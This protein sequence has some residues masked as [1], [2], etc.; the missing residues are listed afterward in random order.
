MCVS[1]DSPLGTV[2][3]D[4]KLGGA[5]SNR[6]PFFD[7]TFLYIPF[8]HY[9]EMGDFVDSLRFFYIIRPPAGIYIYILI[10]EFPRI[11]PRERKLADKILSS[12]GVGE[13]GKE[14]HRR[15]GKNRRY[16]ARDMI[17]KTPSGRKKLLVRGRNEIPSR[18]LRSAILALPLRFIYI[19]F[20]TAATL[21][22]NYSYVTRAEFRYIFRAR[23]KYIAALTR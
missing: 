6:T 5:A 7:L 2:E 20:S 12:A 9:W 17:E 23:Y 19:L 10:E 3:D 1:W 21:D 16:R 11:F 13:G 18:F 8:S 4:G 15:I 22:L 14:E